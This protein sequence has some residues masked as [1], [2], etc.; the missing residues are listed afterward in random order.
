M[1]VVKSAEQPQEKSP[2]PRFGHWEAST[3]LGEGGGAGAGAE[4]GLREPRH[5]GK[6]WA[7]AWPGQGVFLRM[8]EEWAP[9]WTGAAKAEEITMQQRNPGR[10]AG[11]LS[12][13][14]GISLCPPVPCNADHHICYMF[15]GEATLD[16]KH[17]TTVDEPSVKQPAPGFDSVIA[18]G[19]TEPSESH[20]AGQA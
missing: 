17:H 15:L 3:D 9:F 6:R 4:A 10:Q 2:R 8:G 12:C 20:K 14:A 13:P 11:G 19:H 5:G 18:Q 7:G 1:L 16:R